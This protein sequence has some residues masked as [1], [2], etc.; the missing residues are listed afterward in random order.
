MRTDP[1]LPQQP[2]ASP[3]VERPEP[4]AESLA[5]MP[6]L[7][8]DARRRFA[9]AGALAAAYH[10]GR[11]A[12]R[13]LW[14]ALPHRHPQ[15][16]ARAAE[17]VRM[18]PKMLAAVIGTTALA[19]LIQVE[20]YAPRKRWWHRRERISPELLA[21]A[22][23]NNAA[24]SISIDETPHARFVRE[25]PEEAAFSREVMSERGADDEA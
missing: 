12:E 17:P 1:F 10:R 19:S 21:R 25:N 5:E 13:Q 4:S 3:A 18:P 11:V 8:A 24:M 7:A 23:G 15:P 22:I 16:P 20:I 2:P 14:C 6:E 9:D